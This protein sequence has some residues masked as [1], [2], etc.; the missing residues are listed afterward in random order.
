MIFS[1]NNAE[2]G[3]GADDNHHRK[4]SSWD[5]GGYKA[6]GVGMNRA[7]VAEKKD[8][9]YSDEVR[10]NA[11]P[12]TLKRNIPG[13]YSHE[14]EKAEPAD[15]QEKEYFRKIESETDSG[16]EE[17]SMKQP[18]G[19]RK[20]S[21]FLL[22]FL[23][24][25][26]ILAAGTVIV[27]LIVFFMAGQAVRLIDTLAT[28][29][30]P[31]NW[32]GWFVVI[33]LSGAAFISLGYLLFSFVRLKAS[34]AYKLQSSSDFAGH[35]ATD[36]SELRQI[37]CEMRQYLNSYRL[38]SEK[39]TQ[40]LLRLG[41]SRD[42][43]KDLKIG[44]DNLQVKDGDEKDWIMEFDSEFLSVLDRKAKERINRYSWITG[45]TT[46]AFA[47][48]FISASAV[49]INSYLMIRDLCE[50]YRLRSR[51]GFTFVI[52]AWSFTHTLAATRL[53]ALTEEGA[54]AFIASMEIEI[55]SGVVNALGKKVMP[56]ATEGAVNALVLR[57]LGKQA[58][59]RLKPIQFT[60]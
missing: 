35:E 59:K 41:M 44:K 38:D 7:P 2:E 21:I 31:F 23:F 30:T 43:I 18:G 42:N 4:P 50:L 11:I 1:D 25:P 60:R 24:H 29:P 22:S 32:L 3:K 58:M 10:T 12:R 8:A 57:M 36:P 53:G 39:D 47:V 48:P 40:K 14:N 9:G 49:L 17:P 55:Q 13:A 20:P 28:L 37:E 51:A 45:F 26:G 46:A 19:E 16:P 52:F 15:A 6:L 33:I 56:K 27:L 54:E 5:H 34:P